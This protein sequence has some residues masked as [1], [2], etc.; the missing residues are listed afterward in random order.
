M[1]SDK[2]LTERSSPDGG[3]SHDL[4][5]EENLNRPD[6]DTGG[7]RRYTSALPAESARGQG[8]AIYCF[9]YGFTCYNGMMASASVRTQE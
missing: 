7:E 6:V 1:F 2:R 3:D 4:G 8:E 9:Y 5:C